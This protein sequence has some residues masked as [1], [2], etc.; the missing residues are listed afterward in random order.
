MKK[1][2]ILIYGEIGKEGISAE[3]IQKQLAELKDVDTINL[4]VNS[5]GGDVFEGYAIYNAL[6]SS[7]KKITA[8]IQ[9]MCASIATIIVGAA[10]E[11]SMSPLAQYV[12]HN[13]TSGFKGDAKGLKGAAEQLEKIEAA[14]IT[15]YKDLS[16][17]DDT[18]IA[19]LMDAETGFTAQ[20]ALDAGFVDKIQEPLK[21][22]A[23]FDSQVP[24]EK[25]EKEGLVAEAKKLLAK[26]NRRVV[27]LMDVTP[28]GVEVE[29]EGSEAKEGAMVWVI[30]DG[31]RIGPAPAGDHTLVESGVVVSVNEEGK[32]S[33]VRTIEAQTEE[34][35]KE[36]EVSAEA[37]KIEELEAKIEAME[38]LKVEQKENKEKKELQDTIAK[39]EQKFEALASAPISNDDGMPNAPSFSGKKNTNHYDDQRM[40]RVVANLKN[41]LFK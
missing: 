39:L 5:P 3:F 14:M 4:V 20:E 15:M 13:P 36:E 12:I 35:P 21:A 29:I 41:E 40:N 28:E 7:G 25:T 6:K 10:E 2:D 22:V 32:I 33:G 37:K 11:V 38:K 23:K 17:L 9:G 30:E 24:V 1:G 16:K 34:K 31:E 18:K 27:S 19:E 8:D 26:L